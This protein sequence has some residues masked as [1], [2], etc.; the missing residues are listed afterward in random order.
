MD[1]ENLLHSPAIA[2]VM[3]NFAAEH[4]VPVEVC[5]AETGID[6]EQL[7]DGDS[8]IR[9]SQE[10][11]LIENLIAA[12]PDVPALGFELGQR[13]SASAFG[14]WGFALTT[15]RTLRDAATLACR[16]M[17]LSTAYCHF[18]P[19]TCDDEFAVEFDDTPIPAHLREF[20][21]ERDVATGLS[22][23]QQVNLVA[24]PVRRLEL[25]GPAPDH[26][27]RIRQLAGV[28]VKFEAGR[29]RA[30]MAL[31]DAMQPLPTYNEHIVRQLE[32]QCRALMPQ[33]QVSD[34]VQ[35]VRGVLL[36]KDGLI[37]TAEEVAAA[38]A[39][40]PRSL[41]RKLDERATSFR[42]LQDEARR[43]LAERL[44]STT[45][46]KVEELAF[47]LGYSDAASFTRAC[48]RWHGMSPGEFR[49]RKAR[50]GPV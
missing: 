48:R 10:M 11:R 18:H 36:A 44:L 1:A 39:L 4:G 16:Y 25:T 23:A 33:R 40:S 37:K 8:L 38:L 24:Q 19:V 42:N 17:Q 22:L 32:D 29:N 27:E 45:S 50:Q 35:R 5:L 12:L 26:A 31:V 28:P 14:V 49:K 21:R 41:R 43:Q 20:L 2:Q 47:H 6:N 46:M 34:L 3:V 7:K 30:V 13:Y 9:R 15:S